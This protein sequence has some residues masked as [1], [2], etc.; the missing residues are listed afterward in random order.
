MSE[1][2]HF[3]EPVFADNRI[4]F[5]CSD[6]NALFELNMESQKAYYVQSFENEKLLQDNLHRKGVFYDGS[7][8]FIPYWGTGISEFAVDTEE[9]HF[10]PLSDDGSMV[11][12]SNAFLVDDTIILIPTDD[13][14]PLALFNCR[15]KSCKRI[16]AFG[17][18]IGGTFAIDIHG[19]VIWDSKVL[20]VLWKTNKVVTFDYVTEEVQIR[21]VNGANQVQFRDIFNIDDNLWATQVERNELLTLQDAFTVQN[22]YKNVPEILKLIYSQGHIFAVTTTGNELFEIREEGFTTIN[23]VFPDLFFDTL[24]NGN[25]FCGEFTYNNELILCPKNS[26]QML[27]YDV[28]KKGMNCCMITCENIDMLRGRYALESQKLQTNQGILW[29]CDNAYMNL[30]DYIRRIMV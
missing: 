2:L 11:C 12:Y 16:A 10:Y 28:S 25:R 5:S 21:E 1:G 14:F 3:W 19:S 24:R 6:Y 8:Y 20:C 22:V 30:A 26:E 23:A 9:M 4:F 18:A 17:D 7:I 15:D 29:E 27:F 13:R